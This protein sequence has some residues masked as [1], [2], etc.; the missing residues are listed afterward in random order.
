MHRWAQHRQRQ[1]R[2]FLPANRAAAPEPGAIRDEQTQLLGIDW[3]R[4][5][6]AE[7]GLVEVGQRNIEI[8]IIQSDLHGFIADELH[9]NANA[10]V[11]FPD[12]ARQHRKHR[13]HRRHR[14]EPQAALKV[15]LHHCNFGA[16]CVAISKRSACENRHALTLGRQ[17]VKALTPAAQKNRDAEFK[18]KLLD[19]ARQARLGDVAALCRAAKV[20]LLGDRKQIL[21]LPEEHACALEPA[22]LVIGGNISAKID[23]TQ[24]GSDLN[25]AYQS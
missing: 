16:H 10:R 23:G 17:S 8:E 15:V 20:T 1:L 12:H 13:R 14:T 2:C 4:V 24:V 25:R 21:E 22:S 9:V 6:V 3:K 7:I 19:A 11:F 5:L 18:L